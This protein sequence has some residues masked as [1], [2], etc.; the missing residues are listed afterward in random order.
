M[1]LSLPRH[2]RY[3]YLGISIWFILI[4]FIGFSKTFYI[5]RD[6]NIPTNLIIH[7]F[8]YSCWVLLFVVQSTLISVKK[9]KIHMALGIL[10]LILIIA[11]IPSGFYTVLYKVSL[12]KKGFDDAGY[13]LFTLSFAYIFVFLGLI[14]RKNPFYHKRFM[15]F[16]MILLTMASSDRVAYLLELDGSQIFRKSLVFFPAIAL[17]VF[18]FIK[19]R[20][21]IWF[22]L[23][24]IAI[25]ITNFFFSDLFWLSPTG[26][27]FMQFL[28]NFI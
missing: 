6:P 25:I 9:F 18:D 21:F 5:S 17:F 14:L 19:S 27:K 3:F 2:E 13:N 7:G 26:Q 4:T 1:N 22:N 11:M 8:L 28:L 10:G 15:L 16:A 24:P 20:L 12:G 23:L